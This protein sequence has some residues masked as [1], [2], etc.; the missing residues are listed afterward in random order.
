MSFNGIEHSSEVKGVGQ[1]VAK[2][3]DPS[4][5]S[6]HADLSEYLGPEG[7]AEHGREQDGELISR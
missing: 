1:I 5:L 6:S 4:Y 2:Q 3:Q 7:K